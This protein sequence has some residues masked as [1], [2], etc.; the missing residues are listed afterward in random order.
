MNPKI[1]ELRQSL[2]AV[3][4]LAAIAGFTSC[5]KVSIKPE[6]F[7]ASNPWSFKTDIQP[8]FNNICATA[9]CHGAAKSPNLSAGKAYNSLTKGGYVNAPYATSRLYL[10]MDNLHPTSSFSATNDR[11]KI[12]NWV[13]QGAKNN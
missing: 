8:I 7:N 4:I 10:Q 12:Q 9:S 11:L 2:V 1:K 5:E 6:P 3:I 13:L